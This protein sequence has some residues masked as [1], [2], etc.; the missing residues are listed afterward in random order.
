MN[1]ARADYIDYSVALDGLKYLVE[2][3]HYVPYKAALN[4]LAYLTKRFTSQHD[5][6]FYK[7]NINKNLF[8]KIL[9]KLNYSFYYH[10]YFI[11]LFIYYKIAII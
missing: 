3:T 10:I 5:E 1:L 2:E 8:L 7:V 4:A 9:Q 11:Y 6:G